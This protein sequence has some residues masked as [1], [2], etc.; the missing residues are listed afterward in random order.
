MAMPLL[1][2]QSIA[3]AEVRDRDQGILLVVGVW[4]GTNFST[5]S[6]VRK[7]EI[8]LLPSQYLNIALLKC[9]DMH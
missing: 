5:V 2:C 6:L 3:I 7:Y 8:K 4:L 1:A 9:I